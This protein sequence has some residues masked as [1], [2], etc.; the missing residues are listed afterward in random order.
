MGEAGLSAKVR[1]RYLS[2][3]NLALYQPLKAPPAGG[4][5]RGRGALAYLT[6]QPFPP[7]HR[8]VSRMAHM[9][10]LRQAAEAVLTPPR[11]AP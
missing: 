7:S 8:G 5:V 11:P 10:D 2:Q 1:G 6:N 4:V 3:H 9:E